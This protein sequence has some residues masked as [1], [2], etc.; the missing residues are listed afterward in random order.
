MTG[1]SEEPPSFRARSMKGAS[2][3][4]ITLKSLIRVFP[5]GTSTNGSIPLTCNNRNFVSFQNFCCV[6]GTNWFEKSMRAV[7]T[8]VRKNDDES[9]NLLVLH[10]LLSG[11]LK[12]C[13]V[14]IVPFAKCQNKDKNFWTFILTLNPSMVLKFETIVKIVK[15]R[16]G[17]YA[18]RCVEGYAGIDYIQSISLPRSLLQITLI[19][20]C[21]PH[22]NILSV[23]ESHHSTKFA[24]G[25]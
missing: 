2:S 11:L 17:L 12:K 9:W 8:M 19:S 20:F 22:S 25:N 23:S 24:L 6:W 21:P 16:Y 1:E 18:L 3:R 10:L 7:G 5:V 14:C 13:G 15:T 4:L